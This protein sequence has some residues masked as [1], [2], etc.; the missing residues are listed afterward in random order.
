M[1]EMRRGV[2]RFRRGVGIY[3]PRG[4]GGSVGAWCFS[5]DGDVVINVEVLPA[6]GI[7]AHDMAPKS[8]EIPPL[9]K[10]D[11]EDDPHGSLKNW[12]SL[13]ENWSSLGS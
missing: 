9:F 11:T 1:F 7:I 8:L 5:P 10:A 12:S 6:K 3:D 13:G 4:R 2:S